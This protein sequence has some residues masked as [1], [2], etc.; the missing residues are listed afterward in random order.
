MLTNDIEAVDLVTE[1]SKLKD[2]IP[3]EVQEYFYNDKNDL[4]EMHYPVLQYPTKVKSLSLDKTPSFQ[5]KLS[6]S[7][8]IL[9]F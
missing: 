6:G 3:A 5:G 7:R 2:L 4:Y 1:R 8:A 9:N